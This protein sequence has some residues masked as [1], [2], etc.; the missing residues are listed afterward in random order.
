MA[1]QWTALYDDLKE[2]IRNG[3]HAAGDRMP[4]EHELSALRGISRN[5]VRRAYLALSQEGLI[6]IVNGR[7]SFVMQS[8]IV[9]EIDAGSRF[10]DV[11]E[12]CG[13][14]SGARLIESRI[15]PASPQVAGRL[16]LAE[17]SPVLR[18]TA[19]ILGNDVPFILTTRYFPLGLMLDFAAR[20]AASG[21]ITALLREEGMGPLQ[22]VST[23]VGTRMPQNDEVA[24]L[25]CP[26]NAPLLDVSALGRLA[27]GRVVEW[28]QAVMN[29]RLIRLS[30]TS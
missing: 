3:T 30:F 20:M 22:R 14:R 8:G 9:Y 11:L 21:S 23:T 17:G 5:T 27:S 29:G 6:R 28:Q 1:S 25:E 13:L 4:T 7:G 16:S 24:L 19:T 10:R 18:H 26:A 15:E 12:A 2:G